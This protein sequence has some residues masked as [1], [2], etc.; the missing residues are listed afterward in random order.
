MKSTTKN[1]PGWLS[2]TATTARLG[3]GRRALE[4]LVREG[5]ITVRRLPG[6]PDRFDAV[7]VDRLAR[8]T[9]IQAKTA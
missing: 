5:R 1:S 8:E 7:D 9:T 4:K 2:A 3:I 6:L